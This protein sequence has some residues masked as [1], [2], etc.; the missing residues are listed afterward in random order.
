MMVAALFVRDTISSKL[1]SI[2]S[3][4]NPAE[5]D[6]ARPQRAL[7][8][9][10]QAEDIFQKSLLLNDS[11]TT[12][13]YRGKLSAAFSI[14]DTLLKEQTDTTNILRT[15]QSQKLKQWYN[16]KVGLAVRLNL[17]KHNFD[18]LLTVYA[19]FNNERAEN[20]PV[21]LPDLRTRKSQVLSKTDT[22][23]KAAAGEKKKLFSRIKDAIANKNATPAQV[24]EIKHNQTN[25]ITETAIKR[26]VER[27]NKDVAKKL[28]KLQERNIRLL[29]LQRG[30]ISL[31]SHIGTELE[32]IVNDINELNYHMTN[33]IR[34]MAFKSYRESTE[35]LNKF[36]LAA[37]L[38]VILFAALLF[39]FIIKLDRSEIQ[40]RNEN[41]RS[42]TMAQQKMNLLLHMSH[43]IRNPLTAIKGFIYIFRQ[44]PL[45]Q[46][47]IEM[48]NSIQNSSD[49][50]LETLNDTLDAAKMENSEFKLNDGPFNPDSILLSVVES[51]EFS[52]SKKKLNIH[53][54]FDGD[55][56][57][58]V[59]GD[60]L[61]LKQITGNLLGNAIKYTDSGGI[62]I[63]ATLE[64][65]EKGYRL[66]VDVTDTGAGISQEQQARL[67]SKY[68]Q[69]NSAKGKS[70]TGLGLYISKNFVELQGGRI[71]V[72]STA[73]KGSTFSFYIP[74]KKDTAPAAT[75]PAAN[76][77]AEDPA[78]LFRGISILCVDDNKMN[79]MYLKA[80]TSKWNIK[81]YQALNG[82]EA[83]ELIADNKITVVLTDIQMPEMDGNEL[84]LAIKNLDPPLNALPVIA[85]SGEE[86]FDGESFAA[87]GFAGAVGKPVVPAE[88]AQ[89]IARTLNLL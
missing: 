40:L 41:E 66:L 47:Q 82:K 27:D 14:I 3:L 55:K 50:L 83:L 46:R 11:S 24:V 60:S 33:E 15:R 87:R 20:T 85:V 52:A 59:S 89:Q 16:K 68:Y 21:I 74:Y 71:S 6:E 26:I 57:A 1:E 54:H 84:V 12:S 8:A 10:H 43:E 73:G 58:I 48:L 9:L 77:D 37:L 63:N 23:K 45:T 5:H 2:Q 70:G 64:E 22:V 51:M 30:L 44:T 13:A 34:M 61:R 25:N 32:R 19:A 79:L 31:N 42:V 39:V 86:V 69:T 29:E 62:K 18:S 17:L 28:Q 36:Y 35:L 81:F 38:L 88:L 56:N 80:L 76:K 53:Y 65:T 78:S 72:K 75:E 7:L 49:L 4:S 67:F